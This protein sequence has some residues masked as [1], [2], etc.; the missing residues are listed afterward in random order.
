MVEIDGSELGGANGA[1]LSIGS[2]ALGS[3]IEDVAVGGFDVGIE[4]FGSTGR[5][6]GDYVGLQA[7]FDFPNSNKVGVEVLPA[8]TA[9]EIGAGCGTNGNVIAGNEG[10][11][12]RDEGFET[13]IAADLIGGQPFEAGGWPNGGAGVVVTSES[14]GA[15]VGPV[16]GGGP[17]TIASNEGAG[18]LIEKGTSAARVRQNS[19]YDNKGLGI[20]VEAGALAAPTVTAVSDAGDGD[21]KFEGVLS[22]LIGRQYTLDFFASAAC[23]ESGSG[24]GQS[25]LGSATVTAAAA[26]TPYQVTIPATIPLGQEEITAT[27]TQ[28]PSGSAERS[29]T[30]FST[31]HHYAMPPRTFEVNTLEDSG[32]DPGECTATCSLRDAVELANLNAVKDRIVFGVAGTIEVE[33]E[34]GFFVEEPVEIDGTTAPGFAGK[35]RI[36]VDG[37]NVFSE[38]TTEG[39]SFGEEGGA[40]HLDAVAIGG[41]TYGIFL[42]N[43]SPVRLCANYLGVDPTSEAALPNRVGIEVGLFSS[44]NRIGAECGALGGNVISGNERLGIADDGDDTLVSANR[45]GVNAA[46]AAVPNGEAGV[47]V[48]E[49]AQG[50]EI[51][52]GDEEPAN[53]IADNEGD[54]VRVEASVSRVPIRGN[55][56]FG[57]GGRGIAILDDPPPIPEIEGF[58]TAAGQVSAAGFLS[59]EASTEYA[60]DFYA[61]ESCDPSGFGQGQ[62]FVGSGPFETNAGGEGEFEVSFAGSVPAGQ[63]SITATATDLETGAT[64]EFSACLAYVPP[65]EESEEEETQ[66]PPPPPGAIPGPPPLAQALVGPK[67]KNG[68]TV[69]V[70][71]AAGKVK[72]KF[73]G[74]KKFV[75]LTEIQEI[76]VGAVVDA[77][78]GKVRL[79]SIDANGN[80]Q[81]AVFFGGVFKVVQRSGGGLVVLKLLDTFACPATA[82]GSTATASGAGGRG[83]LWGSGHG[84]FRTEGNNGAATVRGTIWLVEDRCDETTFFR[85]RRG[86]VSVRDFITGKTVAVPAGKTYTA[87]TG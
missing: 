30:E 62:S 65:E 32:G 6:C 87:G 67:P 13:E 26:T 72:I 16:A 70:A 53:V 81:S 44:G 15:V 85:T 25:Y 40:S 37:S 58:T 52:F 80:E 43:T 27:A 42:G 51:G 86:V 18:V 28:T 48:A 7:S 76:P 35:P 31:C 23:D 22:G 47:L 9:T 84:N 69:V 73:P 2:D 78:K 45:I 64:T 83:K 82:S 4:F 12:I 63:D 20:Q 75:P 79:T 29:T 8:A 68:E 71:P 24:E 38:G 57:N 1:G 46:G 56:I 11:G 17:N 5:M 14:E 74:K 49:Q 61:S 55:S 19:I 77:T 60:L 33:G 21:F 66:P 54:G 39:F 34:E 50:G 41:F 10:P 59:G 36:L 3:R